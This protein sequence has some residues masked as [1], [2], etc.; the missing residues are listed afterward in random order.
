MKPILTIIIPVYNLE[1]YIEDALRSIYT[2]GLDENIFE[3]IVI[4]DGSTDKSSK[5][6]DEFASVENRIKVIEGLMSCKDVLKLAK[7]YNTTLTVYLTAVFIKS[8]IN[9]ANIK[10]LKKIVADLKGILYNFLNKR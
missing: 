3:V 9:N 6:C 1:N 2:Q 8:I 10:D 4:N 5:M 7:S